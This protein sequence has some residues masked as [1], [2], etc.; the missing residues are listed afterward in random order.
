MDA[1]FL[2]DDR[3]CNTS[4]RFGKTAAQLRVSAPAGGWRPRFR[5]VGSVVESFLEFFGR[6]AFGV[7]LGWLVEVC[8]AIAGQ[9][10]TL[11]WNANTETNLAGYRLYYGTATRSYSGIVPVSAPQTRA[12]V[13]NLQAGGTYYFAVTAYTRDGLESDYSDEV[14]YRVPSGEILLPSLTESVVV[15]GQA[16]SAAYPA[17]TATE[18]VVQIGVDSSVPGGSDPGVTIEGASRDRPRLEVVSFGQPAVA[19]VIRFQAPPARDCELQV[20]DDLLAWN[21]LMSFRSG[22]DSKQFEYIDLATW[23]P[24][25][26]YRLQVLPTPLL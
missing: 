5:L 1:V 17:P 6:V 11:A 21:S 9:S 16:P 12:T 22:A 3:P 7:F 25:R 18:A 8:P 20:S 26:Y 24:C 19:L 23:L 15:T 4:F 13:T 14:S 2:S 10:V